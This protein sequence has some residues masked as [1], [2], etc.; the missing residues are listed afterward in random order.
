ML[1]VVGQGIV[2]GVVEQ[3]ELRVMVLKPAIEGVAEALAKGLDSASLRPD[4]TKGADRRFGDLE[5]LD[6]TLREVGGGVPTQ[7][8]KLPVRRHRPPPHRPGL[9]RV[10]AGASPRSRAANPSPRSCRGKRVLSA[11]RSVR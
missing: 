3:E 11:R 1:A 4:H 7:L 8:L 6:D 9:S 10:A 2:L 5:V